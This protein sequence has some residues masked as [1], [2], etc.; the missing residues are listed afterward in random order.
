[1]AAGV[2]VAV[3]SA[4]AAGWEP[5]TPA[6]VVTV[7][8][9]PV[10]PPAVRKTW[11]PVGREVRGAPPVAWPTNDDAAVQ[12]LVRLS[13]VGAAGRSVRAL[14]RDA[15]RQT[16][17]DGLLLE[18]T[19]TAAAA[20]ITVDYRPFAAA[21]GGDW[22]SRLRVVAL[23]AG[24]A[25]KASDCAA[26]PLPTRNDVKAGTVSASVPAGA[27]LVAVA[28]GPDG[29]NGSYKA[30]SLSPASTWQVSR[31]TGDFSWSYGVPVPPAPGG[32]AP[33]LALAYSAGSVDGR[34]AATN[35]QGSWIGDGWELWPGYIERKYRSCIDD[36]DPVNGTNPNNRSLTNAEQ[37]YYTDNATMS[38]NGGG[39]EMVR[40]ADGLWHGTNDSGARVEL[41]KDAA[42]ANGDNDSEYW[43]VTTID[44]TQYF[45]GLN[46]R[47]GWTAGKDETNSTWTAPVYGN[48]TADPCYNASF[49]SS[50][51]N[52]AWRWNLDYVVDPHGNTMS[53]I[54]AKE[55]GAYGREADPAK[56][57][58]YTRAGYLARIDYGTRRDT[59]FTTPAPLRVHFDTADRCAPNTTCAST[60][61][62][63]WPDT[64]W[65]QYCAA[66]PCTDKIAPTFWTQK[67]LA[68]I[69]T[70]V[71][72]GSSYAPVD[73]LTLRHEFLNAGEHEGTPMWLKG[74][75][76]TGHGNGDVSHPE[77]IFDPGADPLPN[78]VDGPTDNR[79][80]LNR[81]R[82][83]T[84]TTE[85]GS[86][87]SVSYSAPDCTRSSLPTPHTNTKRCMPTWWAPEGLEPT[88]D[89]FHKYVVTRIDVWDATGASGP[90]Q[91]NYDYLDA[92][93]W[94]HD[95]SEMTDPKHRTWSEWSGYGRVR[96][97]SGLE[98]GT[99]SV[100]EYLYFRGLDGDKQP[101]G[102]RSVSITDSQGTSVVDHEALSGQV[103]EETVL[104]GPGGA[105]VSGT[106]NDYWK[107]G[108]L[109]T[110]GSVKSYMV[111]TSQS[112]TRT[113]LLGGGFRWTRTATT[114][115]DENL[116][117]TVD[118]QGDESTSSDDT[119][120]RT[121]YTRN[122]SNW[123]LDRV[124]RVE[125]VGVRC[126]AT[127]A[128]PA[129]VL[130]D[131]RT[132][133]DDPATYGAAPTRGLV[134]RTEEVDTWSGSTPSYV[135]TNRT[136]YD[137]QGRPLSESDALGRTRTTAYTPATGGPLT[138]T[139]V[140]NPLGH[141]STTDL[142]PAWQ[143]ARSTV[144]ANGARTDLTYD[145]LGRVTGVWLPGRDKAT[146]TADLQ[147]AYDLRRNAPTSVTSR[148]LL[149][150]GSGYRTSITLYDGQLRQRQTQSQASGGGRIIMDSVRDSR[151]LMAWTSGAYF[152]DGAPSGTLVTST[153]QVQIP[154]VV[155][156]VHDGG[157]RLLR[158]TFKANGIEKWRTTI[159]HGGDRTLVTPPAGGTATTKITDAR[160]RTTELRQHHGAEPNSTYDATTYTYTD[161]GEMATVTDPAGNRWRYHHDQRGRLVRSE[162]PDRGETTMAYDAEGR[163]THVTDAR[164]ATVATTYDEIGRRTSLRDGSATG[165]K[166]AEW[167]Y[168]TLPNGIGR[169]TASV[170]YAG[171]R[172]YRSEVT[173]YDA[174][175]LP[176]GTRLTVPA[177]DGFGQTEFASATTYKP[178]GDVATQTM[179]AVGDLAEEKLTY[180]H[181]DVGAPTTFVSPLGI[182][183]YSVTHN[184]L[185]ALTQRVLGNFGRRTAVTYTIDEPTGR[186][187]EA[188]TTPETKPEA[189][190]YGYSYDAAGNLTRVSDA[191]AGGG[192]ADVQCYRY[193]NLRRLTT[194]WTPGSGNCATN[195][196]AGA[197]GGPAPYYRTWT[198]DR[199]G[200]RLSETVNTTGGSTT[201]NFTHPAAGAAHP[202]AVQSTSTGDSYGYDEAGNM[203]TRTRA[204]TTQTLTWDAEGHL[205]S[206]AQPG[207]TTEYTYDAD[208]GRLLRRD[209]SGTT[210]YLPDGSELFKPASGGAA[211]GTRYY[212][213]EGVAIAV[214]KAGSL[215]WIVGDHHNTAETQIT[216]NNQTVT[217]RRTLPFGETRGANPT[218]WTGDRGFVNGTED[219]TGLTH[220]GA[221][222]YDPGLG[223]FVSVDT[224]I[225]PH[226][227]QTMH[228][229]AYAN[230]S[231]TT[232]ADPDGLCYG[233][234]EGDLCPGHTRGPWAGTPAGDKARDV[235]FA[236]DRK[237]ARE[238]EAVRTN[239]M[240]TSS[241]YYNY[242]PA[243]REAEQRAY[244]E[245]KKK[246]EA[247]EAARKAREAA[248]AEKNKN[249]KDCGWNPAS[250]GQC[251]KKAVSATGDFFK[252]HWRTMLAAAIIIGTV[253]AAAACG[254][255]IVCGVVVGAA[256]GAALY[257]AANAGTD[258]WSWKD[259]GV[260]TAKGAALGAF[261]ARYAQGLS[262]LKVSRARRKLPVATK[263][264]AFYGAV[265]WMVKGKWNW[266]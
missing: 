52:Q 79:T 241:P 191:P 48:H 243:A 260:E 59:E 99:Q 125:T 216:D 193:D 15:T 154:A 253:A 31:Q 14:D 182:Y 77:I 84:I 4:A 134:V 46:R 198:Y 51:C 140:R 159:A 6:E 225:D 235:H 264:Q 89:W 117:T 261:G 195:P 244:E 63:S 65:D 150:T 22:A 86:Q 131:T 194:A 16:G 21:Y 214:R 109:A 227:P 102:T 72:S 145:G 161:R 107:R 249:K 248:E 222:E 203:T 152:N 199:T 212:Q 132:Y 160:G 35:T 143:S 171:S 153:G 245:A 172:T 189:A 141:T 64:P 187:T 251:A 130:G 44:G 41:L 266:W 92:P 116:P 151:G 247:E 250:W 237:R 174:S 113:A 54:Y 58:E 200:N 224:V 217:R 119:C 265:P 120:T 254:V 162:D 73:S 118:D 104:N 20:D 47:P 211:V 98:S 255:T 123:M 76:R 56:R 157:D 185:G 70:E 74:L 80:A 238:R 188:V 239:P 232:F 148:K 205:S 11:T 42:T 228:G 231:P 85:T 103:R 233:R 240:W 226:D 66:A 124:K 39:V 144:D 133:Y 204:G 165:P 28:A 137:T 207:R 97:R 105:A 75:T 180:N 229:Y 176:T 149:P 129:D 17:V 115:N 190:H 57:T 256:A 186:L 45:F 192:Q 168:D 2:L 62:A 209:S 90:E 181:N 49:P 55:T 135:T 219:P 13:G 122:T 215:T 220:L 184:K 197:L 91:S 127:P 38:L 259:L 68:K 81:W 7:P 213:H 33:E 1:V 93:A 53:Y 18:V 95:D 34:T 8:V 170:R 262:S 163:V 111:N 208:G 263:F 234:E 9:R 201:R 37:C 164:G 23:P 88:L 19:G 167:T 147:F 78:R 139:V 121:E 146:Q 50:R 60:V 25:A 5:P 100:R 258:N 69:R 101:S 166:R 61:P 210:L 218:G 179:P 136:T 169:E 221:R 106:I 183:V 108:P 36:K 202:H 10:V 67:R 128:R 230:N 40:G 252:D 71:R 246:Y 29:E 173:G 27:S 112:R 24:C 43:R 138:R 236:G 82:M 156:K 87:I 126:S 83:N 94:R 142:E 175:G 155:E 196:S 96:I 178:N 177:A 110:R 32:P 242:N 3:Q 158:E 223:R 30:T 114:F 12:K 26:T 257:S 206:V